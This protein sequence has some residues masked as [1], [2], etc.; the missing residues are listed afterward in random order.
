MPMRDN[1]LN[2]SIPAWCKKP[3]VKALET[4]TA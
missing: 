2:P 4:E 1:C 3:T